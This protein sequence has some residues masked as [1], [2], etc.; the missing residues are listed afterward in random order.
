MSNVN[1]EIRKSVAV[2]FVGRYSN[3]V[4]QIAVTAVLARMLNPADFG[5]VAAR[6]GWARPWFS[7]RI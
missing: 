3:I 4:I 2:N 5:V 6:W 7:S 1:Y